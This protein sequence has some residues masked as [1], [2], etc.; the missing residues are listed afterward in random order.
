MET[1]GQTTSSED[2]DSINIFELWKEYE[3]VAMHFN[4][5]LIKLRTQAL[6][7]VAVIAALVGFLSRGEALVEFR[8]GILSGVFF[9]LTIFWIAIWCLDFRY[10]NRLLLGAV[11]E[12]LRLERE[13]HTHS[14]TKEIRLSTGI[15]R[16][17]FESMPKKTLCKEI[18]L[19]RCLFYIIVFLGLLAA[20]LFSFIKFLSASALVSP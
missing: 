18:F 15:E 3:R 9:M 7:G 8:W 12:L 11:D 17:A 13:S 19:G 14:H 1:T 4:E 10:Y 5:L 16:A 6:G 2:R 20:S